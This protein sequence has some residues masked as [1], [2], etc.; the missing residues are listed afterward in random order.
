MF[1]LA[2][3]SIDGYRTRLPNVIVHTFQDKSRISI[4]YVSEH[5]GQEEH[6]VKYTYI[7]NKTT[8]VKRF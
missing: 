4:K 3:G 2:E 7:V 8:E 6:R 5:N 1:Y